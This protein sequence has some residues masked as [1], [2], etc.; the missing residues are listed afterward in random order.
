MG[1]RKVGQGLEG[2]KKSVRE[3]MNSWREG[4]EK[5]RWDKGLGE[6]KISVREVEKN[7]IEG[8]EKKR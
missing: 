2:E 4:W 1:E 7:V 8:W 3:V 6:K 5:E